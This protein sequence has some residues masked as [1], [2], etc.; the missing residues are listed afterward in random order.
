MGPG[1]AWREEGQG[2]GG[3]QSPGGPGCGVMKPPP[4][5]AEA[6]KYGLGPGA[7]GAALGSPRE[8]R[9]AS[10]HQEEQ[11]TRAE[12]AVA[13]PG[14]RSCP[15]RRGRSGRCARCL[16]GGKR[17]SEVGPAAGSG[18]SW[19]PAECGGSGAGCARCSWSLPALGPGLLL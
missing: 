6:F 17:L 15:S 12:A 2:C 3:G 9:A 7:R 18:C 8:G 11:G 10:G 16:E 4:S 5:W 13:R 14:A 19:V 1:L